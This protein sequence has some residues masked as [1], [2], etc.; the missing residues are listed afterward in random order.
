MN[1]PATNRLRLYRNRMSNGATSRITTMMVAGPTSAAAERLM[2]P[3]AERADLPPSLILPLKGGEGSRK[4]ASP[5]PPPFGG[6]VGRAILSD[7][8]ARR[9]T[10]PPHALNSLSHHSLSCA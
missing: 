3:V 8:I 1:L 10:S 5:P 6:R 7:F 2:M 4:P 9:V